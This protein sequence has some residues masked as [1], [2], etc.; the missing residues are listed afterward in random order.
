MLVAPNSERMREDI[1][2]RLIEMSVQS[3]T[4]F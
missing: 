2:G 3:G 1:T 4:S